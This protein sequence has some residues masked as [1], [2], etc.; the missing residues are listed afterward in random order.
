M[1]L[2]LQLQPPTRPHHSSASVLLI[3]IMRRACRKPP[4]LCVDMSL[5]THVHTCVTSVFVNGEFQFELFQLLMSERPRVHAWR[6]AAAEFYPKW[7]FC[8]SCTLLLQVAK[9]KLKI[10][11]NL[12]CQQPAGHMTRVISVYCCFN[13]STQVLSP[14]TISVLAQPSGERPS[15]PRWLLKTGIIY[16]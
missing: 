1:S 4:R 13:N 5:V 16:S 9:K 7:S 10:K 6:G 3:S 12:G 14:I 15:G 11:L 8:C 2:S